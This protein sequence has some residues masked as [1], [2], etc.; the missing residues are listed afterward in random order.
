MEFCALAGRGRF[1]ENEGV[2]EVRADVSEDTT[3]CFGV[4]STVAPA[5]T[6]DGND[7]RI[8]KTD[9]L[10]ATSATSHLLGWRDYPIQIPVVVLEFVKIERIAPDL[11]WNVAAM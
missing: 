3:R 10:V 7:E 4:C 1:V 11:G 2:V 6:I 8:T 9:V 5:S